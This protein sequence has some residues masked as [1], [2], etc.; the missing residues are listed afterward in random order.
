MTGDSTDDLR[1]ASGADHEVVFECA[2]SATPPATTVAISLDNDERY[3]LECLESVRQQTAESLDLIVVDDRS[4]D[5]SVETARAWMSARGRRFRR[6]RL[7]R[8]VVNRGLASSRNLAFRL[9][10]TDD[11][12]VLD[13]DNALYPRCIETLSSALVHCDAWFAYGYLEKF[14][15]ERGML[16]WRAWNP[17]DL[18]SG[19]LIEAAAMIRKSAWERVGGYSPDIE[20]PGCEDYEFW[21]K[22]AANGGWGV[23]VPEFLSRYRARGPATART[24]TSS[25]TARIWDDLERKHPDVRRPPDRSESGRDR[26]Q[27]LACCERIRCLE[28]SAGCRVLE[29]RGWAV[30]RSGVARVELIANGEL[31][32]PARHGDLRAD[33]S[34]RLAGY[35]DG[36]RCGFAGRVEWP[37]TSDL[38]E[39][40]LTVRVWAT[41]G[42]LVE[43]R[44][45]FADAPG[46]PEGASLQEPAVVGAASMTRG[47]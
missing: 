32:G 34:D 10:E 35:P 23:L 18:R 45:E 16:S 1:D 14:G 24:L 30:A 27:V 29:V 44:E 43:L 9:A 33:L 17:D 40:V 13:A 37:A 19:N 41:S 46:A 42:R 25:E 2:S 11:V 5:R 28:A 36:V 12:L 8:H 38:G 4:R 15:D 31:I 21:L 22:I 47:G 7:V 6:C 20:V 3:I 39:Q 26:D